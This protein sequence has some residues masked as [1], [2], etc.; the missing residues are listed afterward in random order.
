[1]PSRK[2]KRAAGD[3]GE[4]ASAP[5]QPTPR[6]SRLK[7][8]RTQ[9]STLRDKAPQPT[10]AE[11]R[12]FPT[13]PE[14]Q[15][16]GS[17]DASDARKNRL[18]VNFSK[19]TYDEVAPKVG[20]LPS[21]RGGDIPTF[22]MFRALLPNSVFL[23]ILDDVRILSLQYGPLSQHINE[24]A[25]ACFLSAY[26]NRIMAEFS[27]LL[28]NTPEAML[29]GNIATKGRVEYQF[30]T[31]GGVTVVF[32]EV[33][34]DIGNLTERLDCYAQ[35]I[36]ECDAC[37][38]MNFQNG[39]YVPIMAV[40]CDGHCFYFFKFEDRRQA[41]EASQIF[42]GKFPEG[43]LRQSIA[44]L[45]PGDDPTDF[46]RQTRFLCESLYYVFL[47]GYQSGLV[48]YWN[49]S[50]ERSKSSPRELTPKWYNATVWAGKALEEASLLG[51]FDTRIN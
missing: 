36:A 35:V 45:A 20:L 18:D 7:S 25:R 46:L 5:P 24:E 47:S 28:Y 33:K 4:Q 14:H 2:R 38:W 26:F 42:L 37:A 34:L 43:H 1:M 44:E 17:Q 16:E 32:I 27:G 13:T 40:L 9:P 23:K 22:E 50:V 12:S 11:T 10:P 30:K 19:V 49:Q 39:F 8:S 29:E 15:G 41:G 51:T 31:F 21:L 6:S 3:E 48:G